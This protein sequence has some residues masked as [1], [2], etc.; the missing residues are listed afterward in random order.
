MADNKH[1]GSQGGAIRYALMICHDE[2]QARPESPDL[3]FTA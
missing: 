1:T 3:I 2:G